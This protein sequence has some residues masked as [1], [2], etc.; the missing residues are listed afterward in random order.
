MSVIKI[1][2]VDQVLTLTN[3]PVIA[4]GGVGKTEDL[5]ALTKTGVSG[6]IV[7]KAIYTGSV[8]LAEA[9]SLIGGGK[10]C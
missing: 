2:C 5:V 7:G 4:S 3:T 9:I 10:T 6:A 8:D 1:A